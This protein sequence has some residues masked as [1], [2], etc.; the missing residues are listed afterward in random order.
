M[1]RGKAAMMQKRP[2]SRLGIIAGLAVALLAGCGEQKQSRDTLVINDVYRN[3]PFSLFH[4]T[5]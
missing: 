4:D 2:L 5:I 1:N 3:F